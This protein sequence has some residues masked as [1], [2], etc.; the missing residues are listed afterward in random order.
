M[1]RAMFNRSPVSRTPDRPSFANSRV[2]LDGAQKERHI[3][4][5]GQILALA[6][7]ALEKKWFHLTPEQQ[8][9]CLNMLGSLEKQLRSRER[10]LDK[11]LQGKAYAAAVRVYELV[12]SLEW[13]S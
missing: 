5:V 9:S 2:L 7:E 4:V 12:V 3:T 10:S 13:P 8:R 6:T 11:R 1:W